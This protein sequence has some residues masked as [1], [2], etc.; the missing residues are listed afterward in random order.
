MDIYSLIKDNDLGV[1][2]I[3]S[4]NVAIEVNFCL[5]PIKHIEQFLV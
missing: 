5:F 1:A 3:F 2:I 4:Q